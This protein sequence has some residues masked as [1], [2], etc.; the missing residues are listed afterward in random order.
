MLKLRPEE[1]QQLLDT[2]DCAVRVIGLELMPDTT[3]E[4]A[5]QLIE[6]CLKELKSD[7]N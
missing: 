1:N 5:C 2:V 7:I 6:K 3:K 4:V